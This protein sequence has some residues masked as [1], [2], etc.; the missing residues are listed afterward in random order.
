MLYDEY[1]LLLDECSG[2]YARYEYDEAVEVARFINIM[3]EEEFITVDQLLEIMD[4][5]FCEG[6]KAKEK[7]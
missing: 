7:A 2:E 4:K 6:M 5:E 3:M 1:D